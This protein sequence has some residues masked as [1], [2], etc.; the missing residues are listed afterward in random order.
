MLEKWIEV[1]RDYKWF[2]VAGV[3]LSVILAI[4]FVLGQ[5]GQTEEATSLTDLA[6]SS[7]QAVERSMDSQLM[8]NLVVDIKGA[9]KKPGIY[10]LPAGSRIHDA[11]EA[12]G[13]LTEAA[14]S[15]SV[16][17][18]QKLSD[19]GVVY[20]ATKEEAVSIIPS[21]SSA[22]ASGDKGETIGLVNVN[23]ATEVELQTISGIGAKRA[24]DIIAYRESKGRF[25]SV[26]DLKNVPGIG[27]KSLENIRPYVTVD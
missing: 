13:G 17:L 4:V 14:D 11:V 10:H 18:A 25:Q 1:L 23:T 27:S 6:T 8:E 15:K 16:N 7:E 2:I 3:G 22:P 21:V 19:E 24:A 5:T 20:V 26:D 12:A 9:V